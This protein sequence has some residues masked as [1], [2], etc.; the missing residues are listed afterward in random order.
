MNL[1]KIKPFA[2]EVE[3]KAEALEADRAKHAAARGKLRELEAGTA[4]AAFEAKQEVATLKANRLDALLDSKKAKTATPAADRAAALDG[5]IEFLR[6]GVTTLQ[7]VVKS[8]ETALAA[9]KFALLDAIDAELWAAFAPAL[10]ELC[11]KHGVPLANVLAL[12]FDN[13]PG[14]GHTSPAREAAFAT[15]A[16]VITRPE[17]GWVIH[18]GGLTRP[19]NTAGRQEWFDQLVADALAAPDEE[20]GLAT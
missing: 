1:L 11:E 4:H 10:Q 12:A 16:R 8:S 13:S 18:S 14:L 7:G 9:A 20:P 3:R 17:A 19:P 5:D 2:I 15:H 6:A